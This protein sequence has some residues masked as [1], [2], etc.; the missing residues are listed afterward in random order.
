MEKCTK[1]LV[2]VLR[3]IT[4]ATARA[5]LLQP[6]S[7]PHLA[8]ETL[9]DGRISKTTLVHG[10]KHM[11]QKDALGWAMHLEEVWVLQTITAAGVRAMERLR[12]P[13]HIPR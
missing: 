9:L 12:Q 13:L 2:M 6:L 7:Q 5:L 10:M 3:M 1:L 11:I 8:V 4:V